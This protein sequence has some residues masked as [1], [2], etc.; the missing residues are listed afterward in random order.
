MIDLLKRRSF[1]H[2]LEDVLVVLSLVRE[3]QKQLESSKSNLGHVV[4]RWKRIKTHLRNLHPRYEH[5]NGNVN[6]LFSPRINERGKQLKSWWNLRIEKQVLDIHWVAYHLD[7]VNHSI[8]LG[9]EQ[10]CVLR[11]PCKYVNPMHFQQVQMDLLMFKRRARPFKSTSGWWEMETQPL[12]F[13]ELARSMAPKLYHSFCIINGI[14]TT[15]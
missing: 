14:L 2:D 8:S 10:T 11:F 15:I 12:I 7:P 4:H 5:H 13:W 6:D 9:L 3:E 1:W